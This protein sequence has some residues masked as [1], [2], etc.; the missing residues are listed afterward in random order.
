MTPAGMRWG[1]TAAIIV[2]IAISLAAVD[3]FLARVES[4]ELRST[5]RRS[6]Q[7]GSRLLDEGKVEEALSFLNDAHALER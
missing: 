4:A 1:T 3:Q 2:V 5:A 7:Q 6:D